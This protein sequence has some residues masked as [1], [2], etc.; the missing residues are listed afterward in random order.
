MSIEVQEMNHYELLGLERGASEE[1]IRASY[2]ELARIFHPDSNYF[3]DIIA[4]PVDNGEVDTFKMITEAYRILNDAGRR[5]AYD[6]TLPPVLREWGE[7]NESQGPLR[8]EGQEFSEVGPARASP[9]VDKAPLKKVFS[10]KDRQRASQ[11]DE[12]RNVPSL[13]DLFEQ[14]RGLVG[15]FLN[16]LGL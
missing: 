16:I 13:L 2:K 14:R 4:D 3:S 10:P 12:I 9:L 5:A 7:S 8:M 6:A 11:V 1:E 15:R